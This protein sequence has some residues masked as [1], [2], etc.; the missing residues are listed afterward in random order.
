M[1]R[2]IAKFVFL[3]GTVW[4]EFWRISDGLSEV[5]KAFRALGLTRETGI[6][7]AVL[8]AACKF[9][10]EGGVRRPI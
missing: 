1:G 4:Q 5:D 10:L 2:P 7:L 6:K 9:T 8:G 3:D